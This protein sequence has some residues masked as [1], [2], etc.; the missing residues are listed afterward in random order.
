MSTF[1]RRPQGRP[2][3]EELLELYQSSIDEYRFQV[4][5]NWSRSQYLLAFGVA[6]LAA[7]VGLIKVG[8]SYGS[9]LTA[10]VF[11]VGAVSAGLSI[12]VTYVQHGYYRSTRDR[13]RRFEELVNLP[14]DLRVDT[15]PTMG[16]P[17]KRIG[18]VTSMLYL[19]FWLILAADILGVVVA[20]KTPPRPT[21][22]TVPTSSVQP[23]TS[24]SP[25]VST[26]TPS[27]SASSR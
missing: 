4:Q 2:T 25:A 14:R 16:S 21:V 13:L 3:R 5:L 9:V 18:R 15:T 1:R 23:K 8:G 22:Q 17:I 20:L 24:P 10:G 7:G 27:P 19:V 26:R 12:I 6:V 11:F